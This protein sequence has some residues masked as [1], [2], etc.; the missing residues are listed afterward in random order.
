MAEELAQQTGM[1]SNT[2]TE[3]LQQAIGLLGGQLSAGRSK[4][5]PSQPKQGGLD[6]LLDS[7]DR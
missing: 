2:A 4:P 6:G 7:W 3:S 5:Q 1:D